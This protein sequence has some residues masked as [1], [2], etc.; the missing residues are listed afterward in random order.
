M[1]FSDKILD[2]AIEAPIASIH[3]PTRM[4]LYDRAQLNLTKNNGPAILQLLGKP[5]V[6]VSIN[7]M[8]GGG[9]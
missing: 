5:T 6:Y 3:L 9:T 8:S 2:G 1:S 4:A 7:S